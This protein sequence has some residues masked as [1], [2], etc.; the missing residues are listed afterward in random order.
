MRVCD[1]ARGG[2]TRSMS[3]GSHAPDPH[4]E[5]HAADEHAAAGHAVEED[6]HGEHGYDEPAL[7][8]IDVPAWAAAV[9][10]IFIGVAVAFCFALATA[11]A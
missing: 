2:S 6:G 11:P 3:I 8:P 1:N 4:T 5:E 10:G 9:G 7:G